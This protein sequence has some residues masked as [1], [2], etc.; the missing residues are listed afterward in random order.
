MKGWLGKTIGKI[1]F[2]IFMFFQLVVIAMS[3]F[4]FMETQLQRDYTSSVTRWWCERT[5]DKIEVPIIEFKEK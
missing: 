3:P 1:L 4:S 5:I 2:I